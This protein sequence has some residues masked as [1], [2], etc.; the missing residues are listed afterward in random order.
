MKPLP[1]KYYLDHFNE[2]LSFVVGPSQHLL[3]QEDLNFI[4]TFN[5]LN[6]DA[7]CVFVRTVNRKSS[8]I[9]VDSLEYEEI[10]EPF[11]Q[12][13]RLKERQ[14]IRSLAPS[15]S[16]ELFSVLTKPQLCSLLKISQLEFKAS[17]NKA[18]L[19]A[20]AKQSM[21]FEIIK[22]SN[23]FE[24]FV[25]R[26]CDQCIDY[27]LFL[28]FGDLSSRLNKFSMRDLGIMRTRKN[29]GQGSARFET[30]ED[31]KSTY[32]YKKR[33]R[34]INDLAP[35]QI[36]KRAEKI[37]SLPKPV[38]QIAET[39]K[40]KYLYHLGKALV[41]QN[42]AQAINLWEQSNHPEAQEK[43]LREQYKLGNVD[44][45]KTRL[46]QIINEPESEGLLV[47]AEDFL[48]RK[49]DKKRTSILTDML[50]D[51]SQQIAIDEMYS[52]SVE[53]G[54]TRFYQKQGHQAYRTENSLW[55]SLFGLTFWHELYE[56]DASALATE[57]DTRPK[58]LRNNDFYQH[59]EDEIEARLR[60]IENADVY[61][62]QLS[63]NASMHYGKRNSIFNWHS[64]LLEQLSRFI[65]Y[66][67]L[68]SILGHMRAMTKDFHKLSDGYPDI[69]VIEDQQLRFEEVKAPGDQLRKNQLLTIRHLRDLGFDVR[70][71]KVDW[72]IDPAQAY[73]VVDIETTGGKSDQHRIT[74]I[75][76]VKMINGQ[77]VDSWQSLIN[78][79]RHIPRFI[80]QLTG[81]DDDMVVNAPLFCEISDNLL[82]FLEGSVFVAHNV[83]FDYGFFKREFE[84]IGHNF[85]MP[86]LCTVREMR[87][88]KPGLPSYSLAN[89]TKHFDISMTQH[90]RA[91]SDA[92][93]AAE[94]LLI[95]NEHRLSNVQ[96]DDKTAKVS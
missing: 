82:S 16:I 19:V 34:E 71:S 32:I 81:I 58:V 76:M 69:M 67:S 60:S 59:F 74:E 27:L 62:K 80:T 43:W 40:D 94:L 35:Q 6:E 90:H 44:E 86:K 57:F 17:Q 36:L 41:S 92:E 14:M 42:P 21:P 7:K 55:R 38:G 93:A 66:S 1:L 53:Y 25:V 39:A 5:S 84:R 26:N 31:A 89:L 33:L 10:A 95:I 11:E 18:S 96:K 46:F 50:R 13:K 56:L 4:D 45:V 70:I 9:K 73:V 22:A 30:L 61:C 87:K 72:Y 78:P 2:F 49:Y 91:L 63:K 48:A 24:H 75:G 3:G 28:F 8:I 52:G 64:G 29:K 15:D 20:L 85:R 65:N 51:G 68:D 54:V 37:D 88:A 12:V 83:G 77:K 23:L 79:Q 47:F